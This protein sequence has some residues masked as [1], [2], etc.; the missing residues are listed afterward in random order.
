MFDFEKLTVYQKTKIFIRDVWS[1]IKVSKLDVSM[2]NQ[3]KRA[4]MS[5]LFNIAE[6]SGRFTKPDRRNFF[7]ISRSS[8]FECIAI[9]DLM[10]DFGEIEHSKYEDIYALGEEISKML[11]ALISSHDTSKQ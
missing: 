2:K 3:L 7:I 8:V 5:V 1:V 9:I 6:G 4:S 10:K 11:F